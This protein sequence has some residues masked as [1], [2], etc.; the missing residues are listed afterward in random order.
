MQINT[1][2]FDMDGL[3][4]D[5]EPFWQE[6]GKETLEYYGASLKEDQ[7]QRTTGLRT[8][9]WIDFWF[10][11]FQLDKSKA[12][13][14]TEKIIQKAIEK[15]GQKGQ[16]FDGATTII[17]TFQEHGFK[18]GLATSSPMALVNVVLEKLNLNQPLDALTSAEKLPFGKPHPQVY[19]NCAEALNAKPIEC[20]A[21]EDSFF[22]MI[23]AKAARMKCIVIPTPSDYHALK[24]NA[25]DLILENLHSFK[26]EHLNRMQ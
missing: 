23:A 22:G 17:Q 25:A 14:A 13:E 19:L 4:I 15:I 24:W 8:E 26:I 16:P 10:N 21:F 9:E 5:S 20:V 7:Y 18:T 2:I 6:A 12:P 11:Y 3:L 1:V